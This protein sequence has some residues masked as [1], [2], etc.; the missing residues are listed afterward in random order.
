MKN[1]FLF[2]LVFS[3]LFGFSTVQAQFDEP[4]VQKKEKPRNLYDE[5]YR[6]GFG[7]NLSLN[8]F[9]FGAGGQFRFGLNPY[10]EAIVN[11]KLTGLKDPTEQTYID[12]TFGFKTI[13][14]KYKRVFAVPLH[15]GLKQR[16]F[17]QN[18][19]DNF[20]VYTSL[21]GGPV[22]AFSIPY[23]KDSNGNG[24][25]ENDPRIYTE[26]LRPEELNDIFSGWNKSES[27]LGVGGELVIGVDFGEKFGNLSSVHFGYTFNYFKEGIQVLEPCKPNLNLMNQ[28][29][30]NPCEIGPSMIRVGNANDFAPMEKAN[31]PR[32]YFGSA[33][34]S[35]VFGWMW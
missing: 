11:L 33:Q 14:E 27:Y 28:Q 18:I 23:F 17:A 34:I 32:K 16:L 13:P 5:G 20:R 12:Y 19:T 31:D 35:F 1:L 24:F 3:L 6:T 25:R 9:G 7:I 30:P 21:S 8:D 2:T 15:I 29:S 10:T 22:Y 4:D 26:Y